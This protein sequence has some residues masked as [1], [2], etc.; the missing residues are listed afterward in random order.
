MTRQEC[1]TMILEKM[2]E[3]VDIYHQYNPDGRYLNLTYM[4][5]ENDGYIMF[6]NRCWTFDEEDREDGEDV[7]FPIDFCKARKDVSA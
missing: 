3:I 1:E 2:Q 4:D 5:E 7:D 6:N